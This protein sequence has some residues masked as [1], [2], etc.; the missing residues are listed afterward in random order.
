MAKFKTPDRGKKRKR[1]DKWITR[2]AAY[3]SL[4]ASFLVPDHRQQRCRQQKHAKCLE[5]LFNIAEAPDARKQAPL[6]P[7]PKF[8]VLGSSTL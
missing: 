6:K 4:E 8:R 7:P 2:L 1:K 3:N 5:R